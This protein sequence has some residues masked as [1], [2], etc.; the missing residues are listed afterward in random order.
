MLNDNRDMRNSCHAHRND[1][2]KSIV[3]NNPVS[4]LEDVD[5]ACAEAHQ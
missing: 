1:P 5:W 3:Q 2:M 4:R